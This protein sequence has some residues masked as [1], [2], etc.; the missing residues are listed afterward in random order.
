MVSEI[1]PSS[2]FVKRLPDPPALC[3]QSGEADYKP[4]AWPLGPMLKDALSQVFLTNKITNKSDATSTLWP[5]R[6]GVSDRN[7]CQSRDLMLRRG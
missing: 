3:Y 6:K 4:L 7:R 5:E 1:N 2:S